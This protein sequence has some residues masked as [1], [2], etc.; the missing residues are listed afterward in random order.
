MSSLAND[1]RLAV[2]LLGKS[3]L[4]TT[5]VVAT[6]AL[7]IGLNTAVFSAIDALLL[8]PLPGVR[9]RR[10]RRPARLFRYIGPRQIPGPP[11]AIPESPASTR[12]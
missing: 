1:F 9:D 8:R 7:A 12:S 11:G 3:P 4:F 2:R 6:L 5:I 10:T